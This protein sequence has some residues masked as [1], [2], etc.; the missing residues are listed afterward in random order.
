M[1][2]PALQFPPGFNSDDEASEDEPEYWKEGQRAVDRIFAQAM[3]NRISSKKALK[4]HRQEAA[5]PGTN[6]LK[7]R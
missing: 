4:N 1:D 3:E 7:R 6:S 2:R 5:A